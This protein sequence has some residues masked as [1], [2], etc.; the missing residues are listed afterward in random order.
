MAIYKSKEVNKMK[1][2][3]ID[4]SQ[5][6]IIEKPVQMVGGKHETSDFSHSIA[7]VK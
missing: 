7:Q 5:I 6:K 1:K 4:I 2:T 3:K